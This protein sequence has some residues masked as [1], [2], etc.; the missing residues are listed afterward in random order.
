MNTPADGKCWF[1][2]SYR[3]T[4]RAKYFRKDLP[5]MMTAVEAVHL[6]SVLNERDKGRGVK[7]AAVQ[8]S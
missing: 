1:L 8:A 2:T 4:K 7:W 3:Q 6:A 5:E